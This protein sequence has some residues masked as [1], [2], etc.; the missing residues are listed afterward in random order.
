[1]KPGTGITGIGSY[2]PLRVLTNDDVAARFGMPGEWIEEKTGV[3]RR[4]VAGPEETVADMAAAAARR[5]LRDA[6]V[7]ARDV[8]LIV[9]ASST[10]GR[11]VPS[12]ACGVQRLLGAKS[13]TALDVNAACA[14]FMYALHVTL[15]LLRCAHAGRPAL[16]IGSERYS[17]HLDYGDRRTASLFGDGA[18][19]VVVDRVPEPYGFMLSDI[20]SDGSKENYVRI[21]REGTG[22]LDPYT[23]LMDG[24]ATREFIEQQLPVMLDQATHNAGLT[25]DD[26]D[27]VIPHQANMRLVNSILNKAGVPEWKTWATGHRYGNTGAA[28]VPITLDSAR[29]AGRLTD[30][31]TVL[32]AALGSG[33]TWGTSLLR[34]RPISNQ[35]SVL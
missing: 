12:I 16:V 7:D 33:M 21:V 30:G 4:H 32:L 24:R 15:A 29:M 13:A 25:L 8:G 20:G 14:G 22:S 1:M 3:L 23:L 28:S 11:F 31:A 34:W 9:A 35:P 18:G 17:H 27:V 10:P 5:A 2:I 26:L 19:A 6:G